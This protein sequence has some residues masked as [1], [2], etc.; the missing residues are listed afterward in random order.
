MTGQFIADI[1]K[2]FEERGY[3]VVSIINEYLLNSQFVKSTDTGEST[4]I[5]GLHAGNLKLL[6]ED[7]EGNRREVC[8]IKT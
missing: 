8:L 4:I 3:L 7:C 2:F 1:E 5:R 6:I